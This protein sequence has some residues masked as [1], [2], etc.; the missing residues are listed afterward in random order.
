MS[1]AVELTP[2][3]AAAIANTEGAAVAEDTEEEGEGLLVAA[4]LP[5]E[6]AT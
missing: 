2:D 3:A 6:D 5:K 1:G 4:V